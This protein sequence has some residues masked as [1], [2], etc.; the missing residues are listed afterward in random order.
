MAERSG[1][2]LHRDAVSAVDKVADLAA[3]DLT[4][5]DVATGGELLAN[6]SYKATAIPGNKFGPTKVASA[7]DSVTAANDASNTHIVEMTLAQKTGAAWYDLF[8]STDAAPKWVARITEAIRVLGCR[9]LAV[10]NTVEYANVSEV[11]ALI[12]TALGANGVLAAFFTIGGTGADVTLTKKTKAANDATLNVAIATGTATGLTAAPTSAN[13]TPGVAPVPQAE[14]AT[15][16]GTITPGTA[17]VETAT[18]A[19]TIT[20]GTAQVVTASGLTGSPVTVA[21]PIT[22]QVDAGKIQVAVAGTGI[23]SSNAVFAQNNAY[24]PDQV[25]ELD[26]LSRET[27]RIY[28]K[29]AVDDLRSAPALTLIPFVKNQVTGEYHQLAKQALSVLGGLGES[30]LQ[31]FSVDVDGASGLVVLV[32]AISG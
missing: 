13:T 10:G 25:T 4:V 30:L 27:A 5:A 18:I 29:L 22:S 11:A 17:Q 21:V 28:A 26:V 20:P 7:I 31:E 24:R 15:V 23:Q 12:R 16:A 19:G 3:D 1:G 6:T 2:V 8:V 32:D 14:T 9:I